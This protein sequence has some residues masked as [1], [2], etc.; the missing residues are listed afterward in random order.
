[1]P[2]PGAHQTTRKPV[3]TSFPAGHPNTVTGWQDGSGIGSGLSSGPK[4]DDSLLRRKYHGT[5]NLVDLIQ[6][7]LRLSALV[8]ME[9]GLEADDRGS[10][11]APQWNT[12]ETQNPVSSPPKG[13]GRAVSTGSFE[14]LSQAPSPAQQHN[15]PSPSGAGSGSDNGEKM[16]MQYYALRPSSEWYAL[17]ASLL[18]RAVLEGYVCG[19]WKGLGALE[20]L[21]RVGL[22]LR[23]DVLNVDSP[24]PS[25]DSNGENS[26]H[27]HHNRRYHHHHDNAY[28]EFDPDDFPTITESAKVLFP[29][30]RQQATSLNSLGLMEQQVVKEPPE[31]EYEYDMEERLASVRPWFRQVNVWAFVLTLMLVLRRPTH[32][33]RPFYPP[34]GYLLA[35]SHGA[36]G[37]CHAPVL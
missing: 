4:K 24:S 3:V 7:F 30:L 28:E 23:P 19:G 37:A 18:T 15:N 34:R 33:S 17:C 14:P 35:V 20:T 11:G 31:Q 5:T 29:S 2:P 10:V 26:T 22:G 8:A 32:M 12:N 16:Q 13:K 1:M 25:E 6:R 36:N 21:M 9:L 27:H